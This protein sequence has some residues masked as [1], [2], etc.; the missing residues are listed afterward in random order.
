MISV[1]AGFSVAH[2]AE[3]A[4]AALRAIAVELTSSMPLPLAASVGYALEGRG[5]RLRPVLCCAGYAA[6]RRTQ[7]VPEGMWRLAASLELV[8]TYSL[9]HDDL[10]CMDDDDLRRGRPTTHRVFG[11]PGAVLAGAAL[12]P[13]AMRVLDA[14][15]GAL[16]WDATTRGR[17]VRELARAA[18]AG[19]MVGGQWRDLEAEARPV[20][21]AGLERIHRE[22]TG[23]LLAVSLRIGGIAGGAEAGE[24][25]ALWS[26]GQAL[27]LA[28]QI[29]DDLLDVEGRPEATGK[30]PGRDQALG[31]S[32][33]PGL[34]G[35]ARARS[36]AEE[37]VADAIAALEGAGLDTP[38]LV[39]IAR[40]V[41]ERQG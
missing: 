12:I 23:A 31:K 24:L 5:K 16:G 21:A 36:L 17:L 1:Q 10:P 6:V 27:G 15:A 22:K 28:F 26:Y 7:D 8:H 34:F 39:E 19:G 18:G 11:T 30:S 20:D 9:V 4:D 32:T 25:E 13:A 3:Q 38:A 29:T 14:E 35:T 2:A 40:H 41:V 33:Y 37:R